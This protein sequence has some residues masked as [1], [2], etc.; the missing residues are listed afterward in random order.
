MIGKEHAKAIFQV[1]V[2]A[3]L[4]L[5]GRILFEIAVDELMEE[6]ASLEPVRLDFE[7]ELILMTMAPPQT[8]HFP[9]VAAI[10]AMKVK[11]KAGESTEL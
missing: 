7:H 11:H 4:V 9:P 10:D 8:T 5:K 1:E 3:R 6:F 2:Y